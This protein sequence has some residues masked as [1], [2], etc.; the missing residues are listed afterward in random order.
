MITI[1]TPAYNAAKFIGLTIES[2]V[3]QSDA[4]WQLIVVDDGSADATG[5]IVRGWSERDA[6]IR[7]AAQTNAGASAARNYGMRLLDEA[8]EYVLFLDADDLLEPD[9]LTILG[10][11]LSASPDSSAAYGLARKISEAGDLIDP[12]SLE[13][14]QRQRFGVEGDHVIAWPA[15]RPTTFEVEAV[16]EVIITP[17]TVL[18]RRDALQRAGEWVEDIRLWEDWDLWLR[19]TRIAPMLFVDAPVLGYRWH[20]TNASGNDEKLDYWSRVVRARF[21]ASLANEPDLLRIAM[22][23]A[24]FHHQRLIDGRIGWARASMKRLD[25]ANALRQLRHAYL[26]K[27]MGAY[28]SV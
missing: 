14:H 3:A 5:D 12:G 18:I 7:F 19:L 8:S 4:N 26:L 20:H 21:L 27:R 13:A 1:I 22:I 10:A 23:G 9:A 6:R 25:F 15:D 16:T 11:A 24:A 17:G 2:V 28:P